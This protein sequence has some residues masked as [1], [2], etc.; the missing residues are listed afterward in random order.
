M[1][2]LTRFPYVMVYEHYVLA[3]V[4]VRVHSYLIVQ[5]A[6]VR[7]RIVCD[8]V[9]VARICLYFTRICVFFLYSFVCHNTISPSS[10]VRQLSPLPLSTN[11][12]FSPL[13]QICSSRS[14]IFLP[15]YSHTF[16]FFA[17]FFRYYL[18]VF[19]VLFVCCLPFCWFREFCMLYL[20]FR[21]LFALVGDL[22]MFFFC[23][24]L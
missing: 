24:I 20:A 5:F 21:S 10:P 9:A 1:R 6:L 13:W 2:L 12:S 17:G 16:C 3:C 19:R 7:D 4:Y 22:F 23:L 18:L 8:A 14:F 15:N 11:L